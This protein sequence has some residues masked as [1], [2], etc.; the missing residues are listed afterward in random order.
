MLWIS[1]LNYSETKENSKKIPTG[2][3]SVFILDPLLIIE[4]GD[5]WFLAFLWPNELSELLAC[6]A[7]GSARVRR[8][9]WN[10]SKKRNERTV[11]SREVSVLGEVRLYTHFVNE[12]EVC[13]YMHL[14]DYKINFNFIEIRVSVV[15]Q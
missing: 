7:S 8:E 3:R 13:F 10:E 1:C 2:N 5:V 11:P 4:V 14:H 15:V 6:V 9:N 12:L